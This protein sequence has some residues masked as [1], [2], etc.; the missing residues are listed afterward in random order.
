MDEPGIGNRREICSRCGVAPLKRRMRIAK[1]KGRYRRRHRRQLRGHAFL[2]H[3]YATGRHFNPIE[4]TLYAGAARNP[5]VASSL[6]EKA[7]RRVK[8]GRAIAKMLPRAVAVNLRHA[9]RHRRGAPVGDRAWA[10]EGAG[11]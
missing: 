7:T 6:D 10:A 11:R 1:V 8:P 4:R 2:I 9:L 3:S 5:G